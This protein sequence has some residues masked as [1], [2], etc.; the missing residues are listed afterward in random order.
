MT[1]TPQE[2]VTKPSSL[3]SI[4]VSICIPLIIDAKLGLRVNRM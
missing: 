2:H 1:S 3:Y 4:V